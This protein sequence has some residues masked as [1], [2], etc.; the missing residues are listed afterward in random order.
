MIHVIVEIEE[1]DAEEGHFAMGIEAFIKGDGTSTDK[2]F[3]M[4]KAFMKQ[5]E[6]LFIKAKDAW[7]K[8]T[9]LEVSTFSLGGKSLKPK[10]S[11]G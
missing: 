5:Q 10:E 9:E 7:E 8:S 1:K 11:E 3:R 2:E 4:A 6:R